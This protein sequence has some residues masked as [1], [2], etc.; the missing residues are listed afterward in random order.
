VWVED[1]SHPETGSWQYDYAITNVEYTGAVRFSTSINSLCCS[2]HRCWH[3]AMSLPLLRLPAKTTACSA[4]AD[5]Q[6][7][8]LSRLHALCTSCR[9]HCS[10]NCCSGSIA[11]THC[12]PSSL[13]AEFE[14]LGIRDQP[15]HE[16]SSQSAFPAN[17]NI[18]YVGLGAVR[19]AVDAAI[20]GG[21]GDVL[22]GLIF[23]LKKKVRT[24]FLAS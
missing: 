12:A 6:C 14:R 15:L 11:A 16:G 17:T 21:G 1:P 18:L 8:L 2:R 24:N 20:A 22:P 13:C 3:I 10:P 19:A 4:S 9:C 7:A 5:S 23:N